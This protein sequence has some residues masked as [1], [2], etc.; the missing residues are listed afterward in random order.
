MTGLLL[1]LVGSLALCGV[2]YATV[3]TGPTERA[4]AVRCS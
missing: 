1:A 3:K 2:S 4:P